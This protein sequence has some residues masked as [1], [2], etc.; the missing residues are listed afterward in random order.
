MLTLKTVKEQKGIGLIEVIAALGVAL[1][2]ITALVSLS[3]TTLRTSSNTKYFQEATALGTKQVELLRAYRDN[4]NNWDDFV[5][6][7][8]SCD[9][10]NDDSYC[11]M[12]VS[13]GISISLDRL[14]D[15]S[16]AEPV[17]VYFAATAEDGSPL[18]GT[19]Q[20]V[21]VEVI[22]T[23]SL[24]NDVKETHIYTEFTNWR[25]E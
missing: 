10:E 15:P 2:V 25:G 4:S 19:E 11:E 9:A 1:V 18:S 3:L 6:D 21:R 13:S 16:D 24:A 7:M 12:V 22:A 5:T 20:L 14:R 23:W 17:A 8:Q